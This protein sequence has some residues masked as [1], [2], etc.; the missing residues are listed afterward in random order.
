[1]LRLVHLA[2]VPFA[3]AVTLFALT[4]AVGLGCN[5]GP[6]MYPIVPGD[7]DQDT[8]GNSGGD[9]D[10][11]GDSDEEVSCPR[12]LP[13][14]VYVQGSYD[15]E[16]DQLVTVAPVEDPRGSCPSLPSDVGPAVI[17]PTDGR[18]LAA[19]PGIG[20]RI[21]VVT[22][23][24]VIW[25]GG[26]EEWRFPSE[27]E[28]ND[29]E[30]P[31]VDGCELSERLLVMPEGGEV[32]YGCGDQW[33]REGG[34]PVEGADGRELHAV[35]EDG[36]ALVADESSGLI[37]L[38]SAGFE[39]ALEPLIDGELEVLRARHFDSGVWIAVLVDGEL[40]RWRLSDGVLSDD[41]V[42]PPLPADTSSAGITRGVLDRDGQWYEPVVLDADGVDGIVRR[43][44]GGDE[45]ELI[46]A[47]EVWPGGGAWATD[48]EP[49]F[50]WM[51]GS[52]ALVTGP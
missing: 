12:L 50:V 7:A 33:V 46:Y 16:D 13:D 23:D 51:H 3:L 32:V 36:S 5:Q 49:P 31:I 44:P 48:P 6:E 52:S 42:Y 30:I 45:A 18:L 8:G 43:P 20:G 14:E 19:E 1:M 21:A 37:L 22:F 40:H 4:A 39:T 25:D 47:E 38:D 29:I 28:V 27:P 26:D 24:T 2:P 15:P 11:D 41:V 9:G 10:G 35:F 34:A 17:R